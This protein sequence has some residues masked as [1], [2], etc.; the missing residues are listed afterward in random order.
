MRAS[1]RSRRVAVVIPVYEPRYLAAALESVFFQSHTPDEV[2]VINDGA[3]DAAAVQRAVT[4]YGSHVRVITQENQGAAAARN[5]AIRATDAELVA[6]LDADDRWLPDFLRDQ[7]QQFDADPSLDLSYTDGL[8]I[9]DT[10]LAGRTFMSTCPS[11]GSVTFERLL[12]QDCTVLLSAVMARREAMV[13]AGLFDPALRRGQDFDLWLRMARRGANMGYLRRVLM[14]RREHATNLSGTAVNEV[15]RP[16]TVLRKTVE[17][18]PL[19]EHERRIA[20]RRIAQLELALARERGKERL[21]DGD[22]AAARREFGRACA[23]LR[24]WK[25]R[26]ARMGLWVAPR[27]VRRVYLAR[28]AS[29][30]S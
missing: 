15:E 14:L 18:M 4:P 16:L 20:E 26:A 22:F 9:G 6:L 27:L 3:P 5:T 30:L 12:S 25:L 10:P 19:L 24:A 11:R 1:T 28:A 23:G 17:T 7:I 8:Y 13:D 21:R 2:I 29:A